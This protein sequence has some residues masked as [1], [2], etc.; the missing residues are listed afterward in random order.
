MTKE[1]I[2][3]ICLQSKSLDEFSNRHAYCKECKAKRF[4]KVKYCC[5]CGEETEFNEKTKYCKPCKAVYDK[6]RKIDIKEKYK[7]HISKLGCRCCGFSHPDALEAHHLS[8]EDK[9]FGVSQSQSSTYNLID[10]AEDKVI[11][12][13]ANCHLIFHSYFGGRSAYFSPQT[14]ES[15]IEIINNSRRLKS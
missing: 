9:R 2:C 12:L 7:Q 14:I 4:R 1:K 8:K 3:T 15:T 10:L 11:I 5:K 13:C 6:F